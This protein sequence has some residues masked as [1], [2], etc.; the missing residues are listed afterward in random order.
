MISGYL[1]VCVFFPHR[2][3]AT[4]VPHPKQELIVGPDSPFFHQLFLL[5]NSAIHYSEVEC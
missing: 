1:G 3:G 5:Q 2:Q 4:V